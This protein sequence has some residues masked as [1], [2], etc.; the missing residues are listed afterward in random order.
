M[1]PTAWFY[2]AND[3]QQGP[4]SSV[5]LRTLAEQG[6]VR[7][8]TLVWYAGLPNWQPFSTVRE[9]VFAEASG[10]T[11][12]LSAPAPDPGPQWVSIDEVRTRDYT[13]DHGARVSEAFQ[14]I[15][16]PSL[17]AVWAI[18]IAS[19]CIAA[20]ALIPCTLGIVCL[21]VTGPLIG[22]VYLMLLTRA[23]VGSCRVGDVFSGFGPR[24]GA[25]VGGHILNSI[26]RLLPMIP[27]IVVTLA[28]MAANGMFR[29]GMINPQ[30]FFQ[31]MLAVAGV[32]ILVT[33]LGI[34]ASVV[35]SLLLIWTL[36]LIADKG[37]GPV[38]AMSLSVRVGR[39][40]IFQMLLL[41]IINWSISLL[42]TVAF[43]I[44]LAFTIPLTLAIY[45]SQ[46][47]KLFGDM[48]P[49]VRG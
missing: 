40:H 16:K 33:G 32:G 44:G 38:E 5:E 3:R 13:I 23:R 10:D 6:V 12:G 8:E 49:K 28:L 45:A 24:F 42:G 41:L 35:I 9:R 37:L 11:S 27:G 34:F 1:E 26:A 22:G 15:T 21:I 7:N 14:W 43:I 25:L 47:E 17:A 31:Q 20:A 30:V 4:V 48:Q 36:P 19:I 29:G 46:Y 18:L 39:K 2:A